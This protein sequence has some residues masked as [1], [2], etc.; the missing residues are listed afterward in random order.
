M[1]SF[2]LS[3]HFLMKRSEIASNRVRDNIDRMLATIRATPGVGSVLIADSVR[4][5]Y[6]SEILKAVVSPYLIIYRYDRTNDAVYILD[7]LDARR[8]H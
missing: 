6:G 3:E 4:R 8:V 2:A 7:L 5:R 1:R